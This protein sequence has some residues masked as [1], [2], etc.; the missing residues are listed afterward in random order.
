MHLFRFFL[1]FLVTAV[2]CPLFSQN[3]YDGSFGDGIE[4]KTNDSTFLMKF[5]FRFQTLYQGESNQSTGAYNESLLIRRSRLKF[6][7]YA[8]NPKWEYKVELALSNRDQSNGE[9]PIAPFGST[10]NIILDAVLKWHFAPG[11]ELWFGQTKLPGN[12]ERVIS[13]Q[14]LQ[15]VDRSLVNANYNL[16]RDKGFQLHHTSGEHV[17]V[18]KSLAL[19]LGEGRN[20]V[21]DNPY[22]GR[23]YTARVEVLPFGEFTSGGDYFGSDLAREKSPKLSVGITGDYNVRAVRLGGNLGDFM[24]DENNNYNDHNDLRTLI[25]DLMFKYNGLSVAAEYI[26]RET[27]RPNTEGF[28]TG[29][30]LVV[31]GGYLLPSNWEFAGRYTTIDGAFNGTSVD[32]V[33]EWTFGVS[34]YI[35][36]HDLKIQSDISYQDFSL[37]DDFLIFRFQ[38][39]ISF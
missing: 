31:Q 33:N 22:A 34:R 8:V 10:A 13:S 15:F 16:D 6:D 14:K 24:L 4:V 19:S 28:A 23:Q 25:A 20:V 26:V 36:G 9:T 32:D 39:E 27:A 7:G 1:L 35:S 37:L 5:S 18:R 17:V 3:I 2:S 21:L 30:G 12:R 29:T 11:W 38:T